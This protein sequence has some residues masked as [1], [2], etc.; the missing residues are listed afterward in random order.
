MSA[1]PQ[2]AIPPEVCAA[3]GLST[4][5]VQ[6]V[7]S[8]INRTFVAQQQQQGARI[9]VQRLHPTFAPE[10]N[11]DIE[12]V[13]AH[14]LRA[15]LQTPTLVR[16]QS[17]HAWVTD[18]QQGVWRA[19]SY[20]EGRVAQA[21][22]HPDQARS[23]G[24]LL[25]RF[26]QALGGLQHR[27]RHVRA[28]AHDT[29]AHLARLAGVRGQAQRAADH[30]V[31]SLAGEILAASDGLRLD[32]SSLPRRVCHGDLKISNLLFWQSRPYEA[33]CLIDLDTLGELHMAY[34]LGD[35]LRSWCNPVG[36]NQTAVTLNRDI[37][38]A[39]LSGYAQAAP[40]FLSPAEVVSVVEG[41]Q[42]ISL[43]LA[44]RFAV[45]AWEDRYFGWDEQRFKS[46][47][48]HN[49]VRA[50]GQLVLSADVSAQKPALLE[51]ALGLFSTRPNQPAAG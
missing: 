34:E 10:V 50:R 37:F 7:P 44:A 6:R 24:A 31:A 9:I 25:A 2:E 17:G 42:T 22:E 38:Q 19:L 12:A 18:A 36:E 28:G 51:L 46:R 29:R 40:G 41:L 8:L 48:E 23:A 47:R 43:E 4:A 32:F 16:T 15:G 39:S 21:V 5:P 45:D 13:T 14:L 49:L 20:I 26:H 1:I 27:F 3:F 33:R 35:A 30:E 11:L